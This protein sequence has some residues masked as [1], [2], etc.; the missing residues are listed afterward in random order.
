MRRV[1]IRMYRQGL[2]DCFLLTFPSSGTDRHV[3]IDCGVLKG[4]EDASAAMRAVATDIM[5]TTKGML[6][7][8]VV[9]HE[10]WD[11]V[12]GFVQASDV[13]KDL[14]VTEV[15]LAWTE[16]VA[17]DLARELSSRRKK[18]QAAVSEATRR[19]ALAGGEAGRRIGNRVNALLEFAGGLGA[20]PGRT[21]ADGMSW[22]K[23]RPGADIRYFRPGGLPHTIP[24]VEDVRA[25]VL[26][27]PYDRK[28]IKKSNPSKRASEVYELALAGGVD[29]GFMA[30]VEAQSADSASAEPF[31]SWFGMG[32][33]EARDTEFFRKHYGFGD[34][35]AD[36]WRRIEDEWLGAAG[37]LALQ[38]DS[39][40]NNTSLA[41][42][43]ELIPSGRVLLFPGDAQVGNWL[44]WE[45]LTWTVAGDHDTRTVTSRDLLERTVLYKV[46]HHGS[47]NATLREKG[48]E[49]MTSPEL[50]A[51][52]PVD[53]Q[54]AKKMQWNMPFPSLFR[55]LSEK[56][57]GR[58][59]EPE[60]GLPPEK[61]AQLSDHEWSQFLSNTDPQDGW[62]DYWVAL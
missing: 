33:E 40:T 14:K 5:G 7:V 50:A 56:T 43:F 19:L 13:F 29:A 4:T 18:A 25:Y 61:P 38:L 28:L 9:T 31:D 26:G 20:A 46:G 57:R 54:T 22:T 47:H 11:H 6:D 12:S 39:D 27:P 2:G 53:R 59:L 44:S 42:A 34:Q 16:D 24:G 21:T 3:L 37:R 32:D 51:M 15:W 55:R 1:R 10:H 35:D 49:L 23:Q 60:A 17:D 58:I 48:L 41:L 62:I 45:A 8:L 52:V 30:A 36:G